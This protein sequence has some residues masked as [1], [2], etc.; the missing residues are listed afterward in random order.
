MEVVVCARKVPIIVEPDRAVLRHLD[1]VGVPEH[2]VVE[3]RLLV[4]ALAK[5]FLLEPGVVRVA[6]QRAVGHARVPGQ[7][8]AV[9][10]LAALRPRGVARRIDRLRG[11]IGEGR[12]RDGRGVAEEF[13]LPQRVTSFERATCDLVDRSGDVEPC[14]ESAGAVAERV[15]VDLLDARERRQRRKQAAPVERSVH[16]F[17]DAAERVD[18]LKV[19]ARAKRLPTD[20]RLE[21]RDADAS[22]VQNAN[23]WSPTVVT[24][25]GSTS[26]VRPL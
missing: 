22:S 5:R 1:A 8:T 7:V 2:I 11:H 12:R 4:H 13:D 14:G 25:S 6:R 21:E 24:E 20:E 17:V 18:A 23:A 26:E 19:H 9:I 3:L 10:L 16:D 15:P